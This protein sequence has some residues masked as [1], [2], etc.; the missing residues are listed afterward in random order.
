[1]EVAHRLCKQAELSTLLPFSFCDVR[2]VALQSTSKREDQGES[3]FGN[4]IAGTAAAI[5]D[6][7]AA[8]KAGVEVDPV[9]DGDGHRNHSQRWQPGDGFGINA[10]LVDDGDMGPVAVR[11]TRSPVFAGG[12]VQ[13]NVGRDGVTVEVKYIQA[14]HDLAPF[15]IF[16][17]LKARILVRSAR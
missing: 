1:M 10:N 14:G 16:A 2:L 12:P 5:G 6:D 4:G 7:D 17:A 9:V 11:L 8:Y 13:G 15:D 3:M